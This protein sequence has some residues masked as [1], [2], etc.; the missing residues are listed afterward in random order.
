M[1]IGTSRLIFRQKKDEVL[2]TRR[3]PIE[4]LSRMYRCSY[5]MGQRLLL[6]FLMS[7]ILPVPARPSSSVKEDELHFT[8]ETSEPTK[9]QPRPSTLETFKDEFGSYIVLTPLLRTGTL[10]RKTRDQGSEGFENWVKE[11]GKYV[12]GYVS[13]A[14]A[15]HRFSNAFVSIDLEDFGRKTAEELK[16]DPK[17][18]LYIN[19]I[20]D[21]DS[22]G[23]FGQTDFQ[24]RYGSS[25]Q[26]QFLHVKDAKDL[27]EKLKALPQDSSFDRIEIMAHGNPGKLK[28]GREIIAIEALESLKT[29]G[30]KFA[31]PGADLRFISCAVAGGKPLDRTVGER[32]VKEMGQALLPEGGSVF[33]ATRYVLAQKMPAVRVMQHAAGVGV[34]SDLVMRV[35]MAFTLNMA[36]SKNAFVRIDI[37]KSSECASGFSALVQRVR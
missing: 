2:G 12:A 19:M 14:Y 8:F 26:N 16:P 7:L 23:G 18:V 10:I 9:S 32:F 3:R 21:K 22:L 33:A 5:V 35:P 24:H 37:S 6:V 31:A 20:D 36:Q 4:S 30:L 29:A 17:K 28:V 34:I 27:V 15:A 13:I 25:E 11:D 1:R